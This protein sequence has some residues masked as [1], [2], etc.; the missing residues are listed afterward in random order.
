MTRSPEVESTDINDVF[1]HKV[2]INL[3]RRPKRWE[4]AQ[5]EFARHEIKFVQRFSAVDGNKLIA[6]A[7]WQ[8]PKGAYGC[9]LSHLQVVE[10]ARQRGLPN[11]LIF[12]DDVVFDSQ[13]RDKFALYIRQLPPVWDML[14]FGALH[15]DD[16]IHLSQNVYRVSQSHSTFA[17]ALNQ[18]IFDRFIVSNHAAKTPVDVN[19][20]AIQKT[21]QCFCFMP[22]LAWVQPVYSDAQERYANHWYIRESLALAGRTVARLVA[23]AQLIFVLHNPEKSRAIA[24]NLLLLIRL[25][26]KR[27]PDIGISIVEQGAE[28]TFAQVTCRITANTTG[29]ATM[30]HLIEECASTEDSANLTHPGKYSVF[31]TGECFSRARIS[32]A[33]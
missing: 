32:V 13:F 29:C 3:D 19:N 7:H 1:P 23:R 28:A 10:E 25:H 33:I 16:P 11:I 31:L 8:R 15:R 12:E 4:E 22:H 9:L 5:K 30:A 20:L 14:F 6:P 17:Y 24:D 27:L 26:S 21:A 18:T 2:C